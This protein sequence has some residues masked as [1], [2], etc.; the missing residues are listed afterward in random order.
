MHSASSTESRFC[1]KTIQGVGPK[2]IVKIFRHMFKTGP[3]LFTTEKLNFQK[4][5][6]FA[7]YDLEN[8]IMSTLLFFGS[9]CFIKNLF[10]QK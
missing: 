10:A 5:A 7:K 8:K 1:R 9:F 3:G 2:K 6:I 4:I